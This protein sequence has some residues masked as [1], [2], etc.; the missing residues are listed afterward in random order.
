MH[1]YMYN[2]K[3]ANSISTLYGYNHCMKNSSAINLSVMDTLNNIT[4]E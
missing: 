2:V 3:I 4:Y 1:N